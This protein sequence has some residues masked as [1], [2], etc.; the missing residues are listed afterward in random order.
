LD[1]SDAIVDDA[2]LI[3]RIQFGSRDESVAA[4]EELVRRYGHRL[5]LHAYDKGFAYDERQDVCNETWMRAW[6][7]LSVGRYEDRGF[8]VFAWL[9]GIADNVMHEH[10]RRRFFRVEEFD[11]ATNTMQPAYKQRH[12]LL[13]DVTPEEELSV[14]TADPAPRV[15]RR[16]SQEQ[17]AAAIREVLQ[18]HD[19]PADFRTIIECWYLHEFTTQEIMELTDWSES[20]V[21]TTKFRARKWLKEQLLARYG[22]ELVNDWR[23]AS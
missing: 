19:T 6:R 15:L 8:G 14:A 1:S 3:Q 17:L 18:D 23:S 21:N 9:R 11:P 7:Q 22:E 2:I 4:L 10:D 16:L 13:G 12:V 20:K 5:Q